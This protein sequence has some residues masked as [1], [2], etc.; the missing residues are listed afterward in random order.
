MADSCSISIN[1]NTEKLFKGEP[2]TPSYDYMPQ[3]SDNVLFNPMLLNENT[4]AVT[5]KTKLEDILKTATILTNA[6]KKEIGIVEERERIL[7]ETIV[8]GRSGTTTLTVSTIDRPPRTYIIRN[9]LWS[10]CNGIIQYPIVKQAYN[11][12][13]DIFSTPR[14]LGQEVTSTRDPC[15]FNSLIK[16][17]TIPLTRRTY[18]V[19]D[20]YLCLK[21]SF[22]NTLE[23][24]MTVPKR[25]V[26][27]TCQNGTVTSLISNIL[28]CGARILSEYT[29]Y[30]FKDERT[31]LPLE[32]CNEKDGSCKLMVGWHITNK[33]IENFEFLKNDRQFKKIFIMKNKPVESFAV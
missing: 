25:V 3:V 17:E 12:Y 27:E 8:Y 5:L 19:E 2:I 21:S 24:Y 1:D 10:L 4:N 22:N 11:I 16:Y 30:P 26:D 29:Y 15:V 6:L 14:C 20:D 7:K 13:T 9:G 33:T 18:Y 32:Y 28:N 31:S 23:T